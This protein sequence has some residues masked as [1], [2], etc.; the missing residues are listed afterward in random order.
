MSFTATFGSVGDFLSVSILVKDLLLALDDSRGSSRDYQEVVRE[1]YILDTALLQVEKLSRSHSPTTE[2]YALYETAR[3]TADKCR[4]C[5]DTFTKQIR[6]YGTSL[7]KGGSGSKI[8]DAAR[9]IQW[10]F[11]PKNGDVDR[12]RAEIMGYSSSINMLLATASV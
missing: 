5:V 11:G 3:H 8:K 10:Q 6:K 1:L 12:F 7:S 2:L 9:K 4:I